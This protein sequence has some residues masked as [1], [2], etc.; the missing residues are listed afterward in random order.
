M[1]RTQE[2][3]QQIQA[4]KKL[5]LSDEEIAELL[6]DDDEVNRMKDSQVNNDLTEEQKEGLKQNTREKS[7]KYTK[8]ATVIEQEQKRKEEKATV[9][10]YLMQYMDEAEE[11]KPGT[12]CVFRYD[13]T[14]YRCKITRVQKQ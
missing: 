2:Q 7:G 13:G 1:T 10:K 6:E 14:K 3:E 9:L 8:S 4:M 5:G 11:S 12:E